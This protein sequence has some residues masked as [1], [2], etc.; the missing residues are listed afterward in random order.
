MML[1]S[2]DGYIEIQSI[3]ASRSC[4]VDFRAGAICNH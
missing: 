4:S 2:L 3:I 1:F